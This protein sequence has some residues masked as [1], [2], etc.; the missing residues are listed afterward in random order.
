MRYAVVRLMVDLSIPVVDRALGDRAAHGES[1][2]HVHERVEP[3]AV[4]LTDDVRERGDG[5]GVREIAGVAARRMPGCADCGCARLSFLRGAV[6]EDERGAEVRERVGDDLA[7][8]AFAADAGE[9][10]G[11]IGEHQRV[12]W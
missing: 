7:D 8:L 10:D 6:D 11:R 2:G 12:G 3:V 1:A 9:K 4:I 5:V